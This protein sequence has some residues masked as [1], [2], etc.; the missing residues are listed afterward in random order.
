MRF[1]HLS[2]LHIGLKL[3]NRD[4]GEDQKYILGEIVKAAAAERPDAVVIAGDIYDRSVPSSDALEL[5]DRFITGLSA[6]VPEA[7]IM[8]ISGN[9]DSPQRVNLFRNLLQRQRVHMVGLPPM[10]RTDHI[11]KVVCR[12]E[13]GPVNFYLLPFVKPSMVRQLFS[14]EAEERE[15][16]EG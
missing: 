8:L 11:E 10:R 15:E 4:M 5:F 3:I 16:Q 7:E 6:A 12:D 2:D 14:E 1:L 13:F 9:H